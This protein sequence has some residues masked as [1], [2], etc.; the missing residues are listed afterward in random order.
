MS[1]QEPV[2]VVEGAYYQVGETSYQVGETSYQ[3]GET[4]SQEVQE[5]QVVQPTEADN[6]DGIKVGEWGAGFCSCFDNFV[7]NCLMVTFCPCISLAQIT[8]RLGLYTY[9]QSLIVFGVLYGVYFVAN[10]VANSTSTNYKCDYGY[11]E[12]FNYTVDCSSGTN[13]LRSI[14]YGISGLAIII[15]FVIIFQLRTKVRERFQIPGSCAED[16][17]TTYFCSCCVIAQMATH[18]KSYKAG[19]CDFGPVDTLP[20]YGN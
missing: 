2:K 15:C 18:V 19:A 3:V 12:H 16:C 20:A 6:Y 10:S 13:A 9:Q 11:D 17:L 8:A 5:I 1:Q 4:H 7:P 14:M